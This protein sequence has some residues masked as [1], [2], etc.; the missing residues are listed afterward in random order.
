MR[1]LKQPLQYIYTVYAFLIFLVLM[2]L[3]LPLI[4]V[5]S[6]FGRIRG[7]NMIY[8]ICRFWSR[9]AMFC[10]GMQHTNIYETPHDPGHPAVFVFNHISYIDI[11]VIL[12]SFLQQPF[13]VLAKAE[14]AKIPVFGYIY[15]KAAILVERGNSENRLK[16]VQILKAVLRKNIS[17][18]IAP[19]GTFNM[20]GRPL[21]EFYDGA[22]RIAIETSTPIKPVV[23]LDTYDRL[24]YHSIF[25]MTPGRSRTVFLEEIGVDGYTI[26]Q[27]EALKQKVYNVME[28]ALIK[29]HASW[30]TQPDHGNS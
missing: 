29:Y 12:L 1:I 10:W 4:I 21:K 9:A 7:G 5:A 6:F 24:H 22:F 19:E 30:I 2:F 17:V 13:R 16:S 25:S 20:T 14:M 27:L 26:N 8:A 28:D 11:P 3:L 23:F 18:V 15:R